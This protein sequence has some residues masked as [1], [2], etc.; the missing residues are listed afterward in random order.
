MQEVYLIIDKEKFEYKA[1]I[2]FVEI[3]FRTKQSSNGFS[4]KR[5]VGFDYVR[6]LDKGPGSAANE[7][8]VKVQDVKRW[9]DL[10]KYIN[11]LK[12]NYDLESEPTITCVEVSF[13]AYSKGATFDD[14]IEHV[15]N[16]YWMLANPVSENRRFTRGMKGTTQGLGRRSYMINR[17]KRGGTVYIGDHRYDQE[18]M[19]IYHKTSDK[20]SQLPQDQCRAR[21]EIT[22][23]GDKC[24]FKTLEEARNFQFSNLA[25]YFK[26]RQLKSEVKGLMLGVA[27]GTPMLGERKP[28]KRKGLGCYLYSAMTS[29][30][31]VLNE[32]VYECLRN[33]TKRL[34]SGGNKKFR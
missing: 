32:I 26:F 21:I 29:A 25:R 4:I 17:L 18:G 6:P 14:M 15:A 7:Y 12:A 9:T 23:R 10:D 8:S 13:D 31:S 20:D 22:L 11:R 28:R 16:Y 24:P 5:N 3:T 19:R 27:D 33:L 1:V 34:N 2:D 30:D